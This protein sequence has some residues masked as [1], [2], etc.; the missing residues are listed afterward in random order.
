MVEITDMLLV[1]KLGQLCFDPDRFRPSGWDPKPDQTEY[2]V[3]QLHK[4]L[5]EF[6]LE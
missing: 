1:D 3:S 2:L 5:K 6:E 4:R